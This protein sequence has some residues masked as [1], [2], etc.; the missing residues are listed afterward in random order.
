MAARIRLAHWLGVAVA[1]LLLGVA[2]DQ[3]FRFN[4][5]RNQRANQLAMIAEL[6]PLLP[7]VSSVDTD[8]K[9]IHAP[10]S[11]GTNAVRVL[12]AY[13]HGQP[14]GMVMWLADIPGYSGP[15]E[16]AVGIRYD[17]ELTGVR[18]LA[19]HETPGFGDVID[20]RGANWPQVFAARSLID[21]P[22]EAWKL[23]SEGGSFD[24]VSGAT[25]T[26]R[27]LVAAVRRALEYY[28]QNREFL[29][30]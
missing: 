21:P 5:A 1:G 10:E 20:W 3:T 18:V 9:L 2:I 22:G 28:A 16:A 23:D 14:I 12:R 24:G 19:H 11:L 13:Q 25:I 4:V 7:T 29:Y 27:A 15:I 8:T 17:G 30:R 26:L 6:S